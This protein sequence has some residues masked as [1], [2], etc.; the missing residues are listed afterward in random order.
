MQYS[1]PT[2]PLLFTRA[3]DLVEWH[4]RIL[5]TSAGPQLPREL[6]FDE[7]ATFSANIRKFKTFIKELDER[8]GIVLSHHLTKL[9]KADPTQVLDEL[10]LALAPPAVGGVVPVNVTTAPAPAAVP[11]G[12]VTGWLIA[13]VSIEGFRGINNEGSP[14]VLTFHP[15]KINSV[16]AVNGVGK[17]SIYDALRFAISGRLAWLDGLPAAEHGADYYLNRFN[18]SGL[19]TVKLKLQPDGGGQSVEITV[20]RDASGKRTV[21][22]TSAW[23]PDA[24]LADLDREFVF[25]DGPTFQEFIDETPLNRGRTFA[26]LL[27]LAEYSKLRQALATL[28]N[29]RAFNNHFGTGALDTALK[30]SR[31]AVADANATLLDDYRI[32][33]APRGRCPREIRRRF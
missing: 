18:K 17:S 33:P 13:G 3:G 32:L 21:T 8:L 25:L 14:L 31:K 30:S 16:S 29:T 6:S 26:G 12:N 11:P 7:Q 10:L 20:T 4:V 27:G 2:A 23:N 22:T 15:E 5:D 28:A 19:G 24:I 9:P 1:K